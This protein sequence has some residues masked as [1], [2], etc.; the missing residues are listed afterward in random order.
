MLDLNRNVVSEC[1]IFSVQRIYQRQGMSNAVEKI[2][3]AK[4]DM[5]SAN[6]NLVSDV[7]QDDL[8]LH[9]AELPLINGNDGAMTA[10]MF[11]AST[12]FR[13][14]HG[15]RLP[16]AQL[17]VSVVNQRGQTKALWNQKLLFA[18]RNRGRGLRVSP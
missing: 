2:W 7:G 4:G 15:M 6:L 18:Q 16:I 10:E 8:T 13:I 12:G 5:F 9:Y 1:R 14:A 3:I 17:K 11:A